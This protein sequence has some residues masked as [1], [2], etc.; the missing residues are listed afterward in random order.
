LTGFAR[1]SH[2]TD[3]NPRLTTIMS[4]SD[5]VL[6]WLTLQDFFVLS[7]RL[8]KIKIWLYLLFLTMH[9]C[10]MDIPKAYKI[11]DLRDLCTPLLEIA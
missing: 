4:C 5:R 1:E 9:F 6:K 3:F 11:K 7:G 8:K 10:Q 2:V